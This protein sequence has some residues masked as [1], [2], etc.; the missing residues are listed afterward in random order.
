MF[1]ITLI[2][3]QSMPIWPV[4]MCCHRRIEHI[5]T[6]HCTP[7]CWPNLNPSVVVHAAQT[8]NAVRILLS[9]R[10]CLEHITRK[11]P[12][13]MWRPLQLT[14]TKLQAAQIL[15]TIF[16][17]R[18]IMTAAPILKYPNNNWRS[19]VTTVPFCISEAKYPQPTP[20]TSS[21]TTQR[22]ILV[23]HS[24]RPLLPCL[25]NSALSPTQIRRQ[26]TI[27]TAASTLTKAPTLTATALLLSFQ[28]D[29]F[30]SPFSLAKSGANNPPWQLLQ[31]QQHIR[32]CSYTCLLVYQVGVLMENES[33]L[34]LW[35]R[36]KRN[37]LL[38][39]MGRHRKIP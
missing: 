24:W 10:E 12:N 25:S 28:L 35:T 33:V 31:L 9:S 34:P 15:T 4:A 8:L 32:S 18:T 20:T 13:P 7:I 1:H 38:I 23:H 6:I 26:Y 11:V 27:M 30:S 19:F 22:P 2:Y 3:R 39:Q 21:N 14:W 37:F 16:S 5:M 29:P 36:L 17:P